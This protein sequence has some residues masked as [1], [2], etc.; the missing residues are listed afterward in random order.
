MF[1][2]KIVCSALWTPNDGD[3]SPNISL[4]VAIKRIEHKREKREIFETNNQ[5][6]QQQQQQRCA[7]T[8]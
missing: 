1:V 3:H 5:H 8:K 6:K 4:H 2:T 7:K